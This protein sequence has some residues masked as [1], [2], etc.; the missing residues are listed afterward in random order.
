LLPP[1]ARCACLIRWCASRQRR[2]TRCKSIGSSSG[3]ARAPACS[4][5]SPRSATAGSVAT[6]RP[7]RAH[8]G[9]QLSVA[10]K[11]PRWRRGEKGV[12]RKGG[13]AGLIDAGNINDT[14]NWCINIQ[15]PMPEKL[16]Q[17]SIAVDRISGPNKTRAGYPWKH[18][19]N[20]KRICRI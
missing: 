18:G 16:Y 1:C 3:V 20:A 9:R 12:Y 7:C 17:Y 11:A 6:P 2:A 15:L 8:P 19:S 13:L 4:P 14:M 10:R 5:S